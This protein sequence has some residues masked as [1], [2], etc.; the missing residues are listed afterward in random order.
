MELKLRYDKNTNKFYIVEY[1]KN[2][3]EQDY[4]AFITG[5]ADDDNG[6]DVVIDLVK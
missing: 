1:L 4:N 3:D 5:K 2:N 6:F